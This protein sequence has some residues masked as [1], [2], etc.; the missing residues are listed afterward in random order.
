MSSV[1][2][3]GDAEGSLA[4]AIVS[5]NWVRHRVHGQPAGDAPRSGMVR[6]SIRLRD[7]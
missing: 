7:G 3:L 6:R 5:S 1:E 4:G 2:L